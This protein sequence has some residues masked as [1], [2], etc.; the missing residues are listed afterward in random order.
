[1]RFSGDGRQLEVVRGASDGSG[2]VYARY[3]LDPEDLIREACRKV[4]RY[5]TVAEWKQYIGGDLPYRR[6]CE[7]LP[8][9][10]DYK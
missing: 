10:G 8:F 9:P 2:V 4:I 6:T 3:P 7:N 1:M 5:L